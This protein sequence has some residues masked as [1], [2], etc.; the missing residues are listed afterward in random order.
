[1]VTMKDIAKE[2]KVSVQT[3]SIVINK[4]DSQISEKTRQRILKL[5]E[6]YKFKPS[7]VAQNLRSGKTKT[8]GLVVPDLVYHPSYPKIFDII[9]SELNKYNLKI[10]LFITRE[11]VTAENK[12][13]DYLLESKVDGIIFI[14]ISKKNPYIKKL[15]LDI[16]I[17]ICLRAN[18]YLK[19]TP[20]IL[21]DNRK[22]GFMATEYLISKGHENIIHIKG[23]EDLFS[24]KERIVGYIEALQKNKIKVNDDYIFFC[25][26]RT[27]KNIY[28]EIYNILKEKK[29]YTAIFAYNDIVAVNCI[30]A[31]N[32]L[33]Y[34]V[35]E[36]VSVIGVDN[37]E[38]GKFIIP[39]LTTINQ[40]IKKVC[41]S[42]V[43]MMISLLEKEKDYKNKMKN[44]MI[45]DPE[46]IERDSVKKM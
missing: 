35:P 26:Y 29:G 10:L 4:R 31:L 1:M 9:E 45:F 14:R 36:D 13:V 34:K 2:A 8:I 19:D 11:E 17:V 5:I 18:D 22:I 3:V 44:N 46:L 25:E 6:K 16:P 39:S 37:L 30:K 32:L 42:T 40:P 43:K 21:V 27:D 20:S 12:A 38:V 33:G 28:A 24:H 41:L 7:R 15:K 23:N